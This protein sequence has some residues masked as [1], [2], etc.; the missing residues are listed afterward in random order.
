MNQEACIFDI[1]RF[2]TQDGP[3]IRTTV[4]FKGC[5]MDCIWC[6]NPE[7]QKRSPEL[8]YRAHLCTRCYRCVEVCPSQATRVL[9]DGLLEVDRGLC[10][11]CGKCEE[12]CLNEARRI[13]GKTMSVD[14]VMEVIL[15]D[16]DYYRSSGGGV[17]ASGGEPTIQPLF[18]LDLFNRCHQRGLHTTLDTCGYVDGDTLESILEHVDLVLFDIK[19]IDAKL[20]KKLTGVSNEIIL[21]NARLTVSKGVPLIIRVPLIPDC[22]DSPDNARGIAQ[23]A[24]ELGG[25]QINLLPYHRLGFGKYEALGRKCELEGVELLKTERVE[26]IAE[27]V[28]S[29]GVPVQVIY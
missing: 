23:F 2:S 27:Q 20:H 7:S 3:G 25:I 6:S 26:L 18:L 9:D 24:L 17:T 15:K 14:E 16:V 29:F 5:P 1:Q 13:S 12:I 4:F 22:T 10:K 28:R 19:I 11:G 21:N 8:M